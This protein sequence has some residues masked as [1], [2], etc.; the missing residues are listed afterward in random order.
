[1]HKKG[2]L[3]LGLNFDWKLWEYSAKLVF[4]SGR[5]E[6]TG[7]R[8]KIEFASFNKLFLDLVLY[9]KIYEYSEPSITLSLKDVVNQAVD[10][11][12]IGIALKFKI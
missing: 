11:F 1:M 10:M 4:Y 7:F 2:F 9:H 3:A 8:I 6:K 12:D 5:R